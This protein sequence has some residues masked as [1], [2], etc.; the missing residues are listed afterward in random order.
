MN[1]LII[2]DEQIAGEKLKGYIQKY[3]H[4]DV[5]ISWVRSVTEVYELLSNPHSFDMIFSDIELLDG[6]VFSVYEKV[7]ITCPI[8]FCTAYDQF[9][10]K[11][12]ETNGIAYLLKP[13]NEEQFLDAWKKYQILFDKRDSIDPK[14]IFDKLKLIVNNSKA[15]Y[16][17][18]FTIKKSNGVYLLSVD[19][20]VYFQSQGDFLLAYDVD[21]NKHAINQSVLNITKLL[22]PTKF[23]QINRSEIINV[24][25]IQK[26]ET[27]FKNKL[28]ISM[29]GIENSLYTSSSRS[30]EF[31]T[32]LG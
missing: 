6:N 24:E 28:C 23:F 22:D 20:I 11:A 16:K 17:T 32:W 21:R 8:I 12:F 2:E 25:Y 19:D 9:V 15:E 3:I 1:I 13:Y 14:I 4:Q 31:R 18:R 10:M 27:H 30:P 26:F 29:I 5:S 7:Q